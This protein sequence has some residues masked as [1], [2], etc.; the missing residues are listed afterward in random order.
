MLIIHDEYQLHDA[1]VKVSRMLSRESWIQRNYDML[2]M[3]AL[4][5][6]AKDQNIAFHEER[7]GRLRYHS[8]SRDLVWEMIRW[9]MTGRRAIKIVLGVADAN[10][11]ESDRIHVYNP[12]N[13]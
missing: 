6:A 1:D 5:A 11:D 8:Q 4:L 3:D 7:T 13:I 12:R 10:I 2:G 9:G